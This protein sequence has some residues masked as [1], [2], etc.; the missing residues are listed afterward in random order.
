MAVRSVIAQTVKV[1]CERKHFRQ[2]EALFFLFWPMDSQQEMVLTFGMTAGF[3]FKELW[4]GVS[5][6]GQTRAVVKG[7]IC[8]VLFS[9]G[10]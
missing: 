2:E 6:R 10:S 7:E 1:N 4:V 3:A 8:F 5:V 9:P